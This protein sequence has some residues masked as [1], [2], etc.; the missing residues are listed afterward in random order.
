[1]SPPFYVC[2]VGTP[3]EPSINCTKIPNLYY[4]WHCAAKGTLVTLEDGSQL[5]IEKINDSHR[6]KTGRKKESLAVW[7]TVQ[8][9]HSS[10]PKKG[11]RNEIFRLTTANGKKITAIENHMIFMTADKCRA[12]SHLAAGDPVMTDEGPST[13][14]TIKAVA[15]DTTFYGLA[16]GSL[17]EKAGK[18]FPQQ[19]AMFLQ[20]FQRKL[21]VA[22]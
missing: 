18:N 2:S 19:L 14:K 11:D 12:I 3:E 5:P 4:W 21:V 20:Q 15:A 10:D 7:A 9:Q 13:V 16:L 1:V 8:G 6:V 22:L 17:K